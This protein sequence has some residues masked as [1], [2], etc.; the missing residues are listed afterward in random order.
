MIY[1]SSGFT[2]R[3]LALKASHYY[4]QQNEDLRINET[5]LSA[6]CILHMK[7]F[8]GTKRGHISF[9][10]AGGIIMCMFSNV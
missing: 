10:T 4:E 1:Q 9:I 8:W 5:I 6:I 7:Y 3:K 2:E